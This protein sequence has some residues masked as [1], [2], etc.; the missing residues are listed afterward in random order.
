MQKPRALFIVLL[1]TLVVF[2]PSLFGEFLA[3]DDELLILDNPTVHGLS[4]SNIAEAFTTYDPEL[5]IPLTLLTHQIEWSL[6]QDSP[7][8]YHV[9]NLL[10][11]LLSVS[12]VFFIVCTLLTKRIAMICALI[13]A[14]HPLQVESVA[15]VSGRKDLLSSVFFLASIWSYTEWKEMGKM[16]KFQILFLQS[17]YPLYLCC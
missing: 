12:I 8:L 3:F 14:I 11:H 2:L 10:L 5:Y 4:F 13:F 9:T 7:F 16:R 15:W 1:V 6:V 17:Y